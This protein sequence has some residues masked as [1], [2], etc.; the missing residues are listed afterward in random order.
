[1]GRPT[2]IMRTPHPLKRMSGRGAELSYEGKLS[3][4]MVV[5]L[6]IFYEVLPAPHVK[7]RLISRSPVSG[8]LVPADEELV[9]QIVSHL[10]PKDLLEL[11]RSSRHL[12]SLLMTSGASP[13]WRVARRSI[14]LPDAPQTINEAQY[15]SLMFEQKCTVSTS[16]RLGK[17]F[18]AWAGVIDLVS[19]LGVWRRGYSPQVY[20]SVR[21]VL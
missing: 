15:A 18:R 2:Q 11:S 17:L 6:D 7:P 12:H 9:G 14:E 3:L 5:P 13:Y 4:I 10:H 8:L 19:P 20:S 16:T 1:M 21:S